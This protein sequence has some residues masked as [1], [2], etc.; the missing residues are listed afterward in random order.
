MANRVVVEPDLKFIRS[1]QASGGDTLKKCYQCATCSTVCE[2]SPAD[3]PFPRK[4][5]VWA[6]WGMKDRLMS[7]PD[8]WL[9]HQCNDCST[10]C[11]RDAK[12]GDVLASIRSYIYE[13]FTFPSFMGKALASPKALPLLLLIPALLI[14]VIMMWNVNTN[15]G[16]PMPH[17]DHYNVPTS[18]MGY[19]ELDQVFLT[20][21]IPAGITEMFFIAGNILI[22]LI[23]GI[24]LFRFWKGLNHEAVNGPVMG[25]IPALIKTVIEIMTHK[26]FETCG[27]NKPRKLAHLL[28]MYGFIGAAIT[29]GLALTFSVIF[30]HML[31]LNIASLSPYGPLHPI[32]IIGW[33]SGIMIMVGSLMM[34]VRRMNNA[35]DIGANGYPD[36]LFLWMVFIVGTTGMFSWM[37]RALNVPEIAYPSYFVHILAVF[38]ILWYMPYSKF[39]HMFYR[40]LA[41]VWARANGRELGRACG[42]PAAQVMEGDKTESTVA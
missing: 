15:G 38:F 37:F 39:A 5:M 6:Q 12:P 22:F 33:V 31:H 17:H 8:I 34:V 30:G 42:V 4:E 20:N 10:R 28:V 2:L 19:F 21:F 29:A 1:M 14:F 18:I 32:K 26:N 36:R 16:Q 35:D 40:T 11:P 27:Q 24:G 23:A 7:D 13:S 25:F 41:L 9:C 3:K